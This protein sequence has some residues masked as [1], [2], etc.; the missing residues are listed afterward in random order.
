VIT[1]FILNRVSAK[2]TSPGP[3]DGGIYG[4]QVLNRRAIKRMQRDEQNPRLACSRDQE[5]GYYSQACHDGWTDFMNFSRAMSRQKTEITPQEQ[6]KIMSILWTLTRSALKSYRQAILE[7]KETAYTDST[8]PHDTLTK[9]LDLL[10]LFKRF[11][12]TTR[13]QH[14]YELDLS[15]I[16]AGESFSHDGDLLFLILR[17][18]VKNAD[19]AL[20][21]IKSETIKGRKLQIKAY[22][23]SPKRHPRRLHIK[24]SNHGQFPENFLQYAGTTI[25][26]S[27]FGET[28]LCGYGLVS[29]ANKIRALGGDSTKPLTIVNTQDPNTKEPMVEV[30]F[31]IQEMKGDKLL[32]P[33]TGA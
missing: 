15:A 26:S 9:A 31:Y 3:Y 22:I 14:V 17:N 8:N 19:E 6:K 29:M 11:V 25:Q 7:G 30:S 27:K 2:P 21:R 10:N 18:Q 33:P 5:R 32:Y 28:D 13:N 1:L 16:P 23:E 12:T 4:A 24:V 20:G